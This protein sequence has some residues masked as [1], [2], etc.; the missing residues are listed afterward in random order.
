MRALIRSLFLVLSIFVALDA[1]L[2]PSAYGTKESDENGYFIVTG[3]ILYKKVGI[4]INQEFLKEAVP[5]I[6][7]N[8]PDFLI[9]TGDM[10]F[11][12]NEKTGGR[13]PIET[14]GR[15]YDFLIHNVFDKIKTKIY[16]VA[17]NHDTGWIPHS[18]S[19]ELFEKLL[20]PLYFSF[21]HKRSLFLILSPY[22][23]FTH[24]ERGGL[25]PL[26]KFDT[27]S[28][29]TFLDNLRSK[30]QSKYDHIFIFTHFSPINDLPIGYYWSQF[31]IPHLSTLEQD[32]H[33]FS[34]FHM[35]REPLIRETDSVVRYKNIR[36]YCFAQYPRGSYTVHFDNHNVKVNLLVGSR[37]SPTLVKEVGF[38]P[39]TRMSMLRCYV[40]FWLVDYPRWVL[41]YYS[42]KYFGKGPK[43]VWKYYYQK[44]LQKVRGL[45]VKSLCP[46][47][48]IGLVNTMNK[49]LSSQFNNK[50]C[51][52]THHPS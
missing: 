47:E 31:I 18:P 11:G 49:H 37:F 10:V 24:T 17:G 3:H 52:H 23:P 21:E 9:L 16:C 50:R 36:F 2:L 39:A 19:I 38:Q 32:V 5:F 46:R 6:N 44:L 22:Q 8:H 40:A 20:N 30:F 33:V 15:K 42:L 25:F 12:E 26:K 13:L 34:T 7:E 29:R 48:G 27:P 14:I 35:T 4:G 43:S 28:S 51:I 45:F 41:R 1:F